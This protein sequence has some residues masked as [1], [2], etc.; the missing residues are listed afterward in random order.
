MLTVLRS[1]RFG[2]P[3]VTPPS[4]ATL[5]II[6]A[7]CFSTGGRAAPFDH[8]P[9]VQ[10]GVESS[11][12]ITLRSVLCATALSAMIPAGG[13]HRTS[14][15]IGAAEFRYATSPPASR[16][17]REAIVHQLARSESPPAAASC[18]RAHAARQDDDADY[19]QLFFDPVRMPKHLLLPCPPS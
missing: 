7:I 6:S 3:D 13:V 17:R 5:R 11:S 14:S 8:S 10:I 9:D 12:G 18:V 4:P 16:H 19:A 1:Q 2:P 15:I